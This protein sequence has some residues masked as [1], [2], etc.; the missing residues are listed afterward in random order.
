M[1]K[2]N[3]WINQKKATLSS[4]QQQVYNL[5]TL[6]KQLQAFLPEEWHSYCQVVRCD[7]N[8]HVLVLSTSEQSLLTPLRYMQNQILMQ[9]KKRSTT[10]KS[11]E[12]IECIY[13]PA[14]ID[15]IKPRRPQIANDAAE[16]C[17]QAA[18][19]CPPALKAALEKLS[20]TLMK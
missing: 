6:T 13:T 20:K 16:A 15:K 3:S 19:K 11:I 10:F 5:N 17:K 4:I 8:D 18:E 7:S 2:I 14:P 9:L 12:K 1:K